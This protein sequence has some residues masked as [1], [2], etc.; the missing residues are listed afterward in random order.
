MCSIYS[1]HPMPQQLAAY[2]WTEGLKIKDLTLEAIRQ[3][4]IRADE[5]NLR[6]FAPHHRVP[7]R[8]DDPTTADD[9]NQDKASAS[10]ASDLPWELSR[11]TINPT[12]SLNGN[13][14]SNNEGHISRKTT[15]PWKR[16]KKE[17]SREEGSESEANEENECEEG[18][19]DWTSEELLELRQEKDS[20]W[21][22]TE[23]V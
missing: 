5:V 13:K 17:T 15:S 9:E 19:A 1:C 22:R 18:N 14:P 23:D 16:S 2:L 6:M 3:A 8:Y 20:I 21:I 10:D 4:L 11:C 12:E 7:I